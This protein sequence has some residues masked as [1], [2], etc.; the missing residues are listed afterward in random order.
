MITKVDPNNLQIVGTQSALAKIKDATVVADADKGGRRRF[1]QVKV[2]EGVPCV[3]V[4][5]YFDA[6]VGKFQIDPNKVLIVPADEE[7][8]FLKIEGGVSIYETP[9]ERRD[10]LQS[11]MDMQ[12]IV[13]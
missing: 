9:A 13:H 2:F 1:G 4:P 12:E 7:L 11:E 3:K 10:D 8:V 5:N 6:E